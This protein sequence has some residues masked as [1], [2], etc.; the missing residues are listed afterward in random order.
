MLGPT[1]TRARRGQFG[2]VILWIPVVCFIVAAS[3]VSG[4][5]RLFGRSPRSRLTDRDPEQ[6]VI[7]NAYAKW[8]PIY[9]LVCGP[10]FLNARRVTARAA[11]K[12]GGRILEIGVPK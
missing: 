7:Q 4:V 11:R 5:L 2:V 12:V 3:V 6:D 1:Y 10:I 8:A 9:D